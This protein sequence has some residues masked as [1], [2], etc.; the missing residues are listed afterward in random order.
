ML[1]KPYQYLSNKRMPSIE[2]GFSL[3]EAMVAMAILTIS[4]VGVGYALVSSDQE[5]TTVE[6]V[7]QNQQ[8]G[9]TQATAMTGSVSCAG[10]QTTQK[11]IT[12]S[13]RKSA[14]AAT[15][16]SV[17]VPIASLSSSFSA[18]PNNQQPPAW[19]QP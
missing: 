15:V 10:A 8:C 16:S 6:Y 4:A 11:I 17:Q 5:L 19:W 13:M 2:S 7:S 1:G 14:S 18:V 9:M 3:V 12:V